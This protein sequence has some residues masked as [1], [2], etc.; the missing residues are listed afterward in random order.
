MKFKFHCGGLRNK[1]MMRECA[2]LISWGIGKH[3]S[4]M[5]PLLHLQKGLH[6]CRMAIW[7]GEMVGELNSQEFHG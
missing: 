1:G 4:P 7:G 3:F 2:L 6:A 5:S